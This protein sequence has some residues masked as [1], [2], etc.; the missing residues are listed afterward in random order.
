MQLLQLTSAALNQNLVTSFILTT[1]NFPPE[2]KNYF[3]IRTFFITCSIGIISIILYS[4]CN[5]AYI[6]V[7]LAE[8][9]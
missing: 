6:T 2:T 1:G 7:P 9:G 3:K 4:T 8:G 5:L